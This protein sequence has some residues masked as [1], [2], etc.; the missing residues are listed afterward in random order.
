MVGGEEGDR[1]REKYAKMYRW[2]TTE[3]YI[4]W[5]QSSLH[6]FIITPWDSGML[7]KK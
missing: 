5:I 6:T 1:E 7:D 2:K 3:P 4:M